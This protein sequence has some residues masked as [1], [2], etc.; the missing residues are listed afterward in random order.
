MPIA[1]FAQSRLLLALG[2]LVSVSSTAEGRRW[3]YHGSY[4]YYGYYDRSLANPH[5][6]A[7]KQAGQSIGFGAS[8]AKM[9]RACEG[10]ITELKN[11][12]FEFIARTVRPNGR[13]Q[14]AL[15]EV[16]SATIGA[17]DTLSST[18]P[19]D[20]LPPE[21]RAVNTDRPST[22]TTRPPCGAMR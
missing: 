15:D 18:C 3:R 17:A 10:D 12:P 7:S 1:R 20:V 13:Q 6:Q 4:G 16:R 21:Q 9:I 19:K 8:V 2:V 5:E 14:D 22:T 11:T